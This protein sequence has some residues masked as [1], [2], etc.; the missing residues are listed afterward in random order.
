MVYRI[1]WRVFVL[2][3]ALAL[4]AGAYL[5]GG[6]LEPPG[7]PESTMLPLDELDPRRPIHADMLPL[8]ITDKGSSWYLAES[9][10]VASGDG[11]IVD[12]DDVTIDLNGFSLRGGSGWGIRNSEPSINTPGGTTVK[13]GTIE[14]WLAGGIR[15]GERST[16]ENVLVRHN[17]GT[18][19]QLHQDGR[20]IDCVVLGN[21]V[22]G[23]IVY[24]GSL[25]R[26]STA[27]ANVEN[28]IWSNSTSASA[29]GALIQNCV[30]E[31]NDKNGIRVDGGAFVLNNQI[32]MNDESGA[33]TK[34]GVWVNGDHNRVD[35]NH[36]T[37]NYVGIDLTGN[38]NI[39]VRNSVLNNTD[40][41]YINPGAIGN[42][43]DIAV[44][45]TSNPWANFCMG[46]CP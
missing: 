30:V 35:G 38:E 3:T 19:I 18:G 24:S 15:L 46:V 16:V 13:N 23:I 27:S 4:L 36:I 32:R 37:D 28:G 20:V 39:I 22:H 34:A 43:V 9:I 10:P 25:V 6:P 12:A 33:Q 45:I 5:L 29:K 11:I 2:P 8:T 14:S 21:A 40:N 7:P 31:N 41:F 42:V 1:R 26:G 17:E 44:G